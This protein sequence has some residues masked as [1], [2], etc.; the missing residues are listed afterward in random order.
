MWGHV[1]VNIL[2]FRCLAQ[3]RYHFSYCCFLVIAFPWAIIPCLSNPVHIITSSYFFYLFKGYVSYNL[4]EESVTEL[5]IHHLLYFR[6]KGNWRDLVQ[7]VSSPFYIGFH[8][9]FGSI[10]LK[11][12]LHLPQPAALH[13]FHCLQFQMRPVLSP[14]NLIL[15]RRG[16]FGDW[17]ERTQ[18][19]LSTGMMKAKNIGMN[20][21]SH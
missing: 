13:V 15:I 19:R 11:N 21:E 16:E 1:V 2:Y 8:S 3:S 9:L 14:N 7:I 4:K 6:P 10:E 20:G 12:V 18:D 17:N 5:M